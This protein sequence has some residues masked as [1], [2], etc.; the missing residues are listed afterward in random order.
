[1]T[2]LLCILWLIGGFVIGV[3]AGAHWF[4]RC[5]AS[6]IRRGTMRSII[7]DYERTLAE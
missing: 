3:M 7:E 5:V 6:S 1:M 2:L 4:A